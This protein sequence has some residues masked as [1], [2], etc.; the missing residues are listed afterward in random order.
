MNF[1]ILLVF[2][3]VVEAVG[4]AIGLFFIPGEWYAG[5]AKPPFSPP[6]QIFGI[7]WPALYL[8]VAIAGWRVFTRKI[9]GWGLWVGQMVL[10]WTWSPVFFG[11]HLIFWGIWVI[12]GAFVLSLAFIATSWKHDRIAAWCFVPYAAWLGF[13]LLLN[14][15]VWWLN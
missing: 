7:V 2:I 9:E 6:N 3:I 12:L 11:L 13:A 5:L 1:L 8:L 10:N 14:V 15:S 4:A